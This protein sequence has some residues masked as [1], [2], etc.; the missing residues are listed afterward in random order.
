MQAEKTC[1]VM[2]AEGG[3]I[4]QL[5]HIFKV[6]GLCIQQKS[7]M[8]HSVIMQ[9]LGKRCLV[10][11]ADSEASAKQQHQQ[12]NAGQRSAQGTAKAL[13]WFDTVIQ[14]DDTRAPLDTFEQ[15]GQVPEPL[16]VATFF[17]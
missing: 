1:E 7:L 6:D 17:F 4:L 14:E 11:A 5:L 10:G 3:I 9:Q 15:A 16:S 13:H 8:Q 2:T 12:Q